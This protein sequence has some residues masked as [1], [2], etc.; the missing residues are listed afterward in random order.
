MYTAL[1]IYLTG[2]LSCN[3]GRCVQR[4]HVT[5]QYVAPSSF[6]RSNRSVYLPTSS[7][8]AR[9]PSRL[10]STT[11]LVDTSPWF[12]SEQHRTQLLVIKMASALQIHEYEPTEGDDHLAST[13][14]CSQFAG[15]TTTEHDDQFSFVPLPHDSAMLGDFKPSDG[16]ILTAM[17]IAEVD[18]AYALSG[19]YGTSPDNN[20]IFTGEDGS[21]ISTVREIVGE[22]DPAMNGWGWGNRRKRKKHAAMT[23]EQQESSI[24]QL[25]ATLRLH[26]LPTTTTTSKNAPS[27]VT[28]S[29]L[30]YSSQSNSST[31]PFTDPSEDGDTCE[32]KQ[33]SGRPTNDPAL[34]KRRAK[35]IGEGK[36]TRK[37]QS[38]NLPPETKYAIGLLQRFGNPFDKEISDVVEYASGILVSQENIEGPFEE[39]MAMQRDWKV[40]HA[41]CLRKMTTFLE[42]YG[43]IPIGGVEAMASETS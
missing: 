33:G 7:E 28:L 37:D 10:H 26:Q 27:L 43:M 9:D 6:A 18:A 15:R 13:P 31:K 36:K 40:A 3:L 32:K 42:R 1:R 20:V 34:H 25:K 39:L 4:R 29:D 8:I 41:E 16:D 2:G 5:V 21:E 19:G 23:K 12:V 22:L 35:T 24:I 30:E 14:S 11:T 38:L 17:Q